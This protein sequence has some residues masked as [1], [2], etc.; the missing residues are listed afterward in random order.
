[1]M[2][3]V[4]APD[5]AI[6]PPPGWS[7]GP[8][9][10]TGGSAVVYEVRAGS[11]A[12]AV[13][14]W[15]RWRDRDIH[16]RFVREAEVLQQLGPPATPAY[17]DH[18]AIDDWPYILMEEVPGETLAAWMARTGE[19]G[20]LG[21]IVTLLTRIAGVL[22]II[23]R[24]GY[25]HRDLKPENILISTADT[26]ILDYGLATADRGGV[27]QLGTIAGTVHYLAP[28]QV[29]TGSTIDQRSDIYSFG[30]I[31]FEMIAG[32]PPFIGERRAIEYQHQVAKPPPLRE[33]RAD[34]P[35]ELESFVNGCLAKQPE[36]RP[37][38]AEYLADMLATA[39]SCIQTLKGVGHAPKKVLAARDRV[40]LA[41]IEGGDP[42]TVARTIADVHGM[43]VRSRV[44]GILAAFASMHHPAPLVVALSA[45]RELARQ[46]CRVV[47]HVD[48]LLLRRSAHG[49]P[50][51]YG[52]AIEQIASWTP[53]TPFTGVVLTAAAA[54]MAGSGMASAH[55]LPDFWREVHRDRT[56][57]TEPQVE[58]PFVG[59]DRLVQDVAA[60]AGA[61]GM[62]IGVSGESGA[63]KTRFAGALVD[64]LRGARREVISLRARRRLFGDRADDTRLL[65]ALGDASDLVT[66][67]VDAGSRRAIIVIDDAH[68][69]S[70]RAQRQLL[71]DDLAV[72]RV[73]MSR[74]PLFEVA[75]GTTRRLAIGIPPLEFPDAQRLLRHL[76]QPAQ[77]IPD[78]LLERLALR[79]SGNPG[80]LVALARDIRDRGG[81]RRHGGSDE[82]Y[83][84]ADEIDTLLVAP[85]TAWLAN[86]A[87]EMLPIELA[88]IVRT[89]AA[90]GPRFSREELHGVT[91][92]EPSA[93]LELLVRDGVFTQHH[94]WYEFVDPALQEGLYDYELEERAIVHGR[95]LR[96]WLANRP[97]DTVGWLA[98]VAHHAA[99]SG[100]LA[101]AATCYSTLAREARQH[102]ELALADQLDA[103]AMHCLTNAA[104]TAVADVVR[105]M[106]DE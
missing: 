51:F 6:T 7:L 77:L 64:R 102:D 61:G 60:V 34:I 23:H 55:D 83:I 32:Q 39:T 58:I 82:W 38:S 101:T 42:I 18:G 37:Q 69:C 104:P 46:R 98:R 73:L 72:G 13:L 9:L 3:D 41:W 75:P 33:I 90:L 91:G 10:A 1:M 76:L 54:Q 44:G 106:I 50:M 5:V 20:A 57:A 74:E 86:R 12:P 71:R 67:L 15:G 84:A 19:Q 88:P 87:L 26:R 49:K 99:G 65:E 66:G 92:S 96:Y 62:V 80:L 2:F 103:R 30:V 93:R 53:R 105:R 95:A 11:G 28:E 52:P 45:A 8:L 17:I 31:A 85:S 35:V 16:A 79:A 29:R 24:A 100:D 40:V 70:E 89:A 48:D 97:A 59:R 14:K 4:D 27:G 94:G 78:V 25:V 36:A 47:L 22:R 43:I 68:L 21:E 63:G 81:V 56:D